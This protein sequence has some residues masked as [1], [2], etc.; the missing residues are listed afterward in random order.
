M[1]FF[2]TFNTSGFKLIN[3]SSETAIYAVI[4]ILAKVGF[5]I[6]LNR[7]PQVLAEA[8]SSMMEAVHSYTLSGESGRIRQE[9]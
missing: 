9:T 8:S 2:L 7:S 6:I 1:R 4:D 3:T 5:G